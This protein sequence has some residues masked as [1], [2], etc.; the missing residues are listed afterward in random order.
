MKKK[1][2]P[3][4]IFSRLVGLVKKLNVFIIFH[5]NYKNLNQNDIFLYNRYSVNLQ[6]DKI[7]K[8][9]PCSLSFIILLVCFIKRLGRKPPGISESFVTVF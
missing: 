8:I 2:N 5:L 1:L 7:N 4:V 6:I 3:F 9:R